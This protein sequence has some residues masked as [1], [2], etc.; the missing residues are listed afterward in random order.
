MNDKDY[1]EM[2]KLVYRIGEDVKEISRI[3]DYY[4][5]V[6]KRELFHDK[7]EKEESNGNV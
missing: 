6:P 3:L 2:R 7:L 5:E 4:K 1:E